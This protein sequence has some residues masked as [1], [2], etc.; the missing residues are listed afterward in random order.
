[1]S[2]RD[3]GYIRKDFDTYDTPL[4]VTRALAP[5]LRDGL[6][7][8]EPAAGNG[9]I[10]D[11]LDPYR[12]GNMISTSVVTDIQTG[13]DFLAATALPTQHITAII[14]N[15]PYTAAT[16]FI[17]H[18]LDLMKPVKGLVA[19]LLRTDFDHAKSRRHLFADHPAFCK[20]I[21]LL[22]RIVWFEPEPGS[23]G[24]SPSENHAWWIWDWQHRGWPTIA[25]E[26][27]P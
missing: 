27:K 2:Q 4:W 6:C 26:G 18:A 1:M 11:V 25:Y 5:H 3:S 10:M 23:K 9:A 22:N 17:E 13:H 24:K 12:R 7:V 21:V 15:P 16:E 8:W 20:K 14:T 19:M